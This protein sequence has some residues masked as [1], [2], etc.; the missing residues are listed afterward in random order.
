MQTRGLDQL[1]EHMR[2]AVER[3]VQHGIAGGSFLTAVL[4]NRLVQ[5]Y[6]RA[7][8]ANTAAMQA[9]AGWLWNDAP[10]DCWG[11]PE[12]VEGWIAIGGLRGLQD[13]EVA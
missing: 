13:R 10:G 8:E 6:G 11:S 4:S 5:A 3:Y 2:D 9:W 7:D 1:P 12:K